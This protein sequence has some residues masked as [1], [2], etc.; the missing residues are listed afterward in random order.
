MR[1]DLLAGN[2]LAV[3]LERV[4]RVWAQAVLGVVAGLLCAL[5]GSSALLVDVVGD[6]AGLST[7]LA[8]GVGRLAAGVGSRHFGMRFG[9]REGLFGV[10][11]W[12]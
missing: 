3:L 12:S 4:R 2:L 10:S 6:L 11:A 5:L 7:R 8:R 9:W 1:L